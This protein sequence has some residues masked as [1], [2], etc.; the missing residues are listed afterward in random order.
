MAHRVRVAGLAIAAGIC[1][2]SV[3]ALNGHAQAPV[4]GPASASPTAVCV[5]CRGPDV[6]YRCEVKDSHRVERIRGSPRALEFVCITE[7]AKAG[8]HQSCRAGSN[9][10]GPCIG[11]PRLID[12]SKSG[13]AVVIG[14][15]PAGP[16]AAVGGVQAP[17]VATTSERTS[18]KPD[19]PPQTLEELARVTVSK[20]KKQIAEADEKMQEASGAVG[21]ALKKSWACLSSLFTDCK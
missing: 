16:P 13:D 7:L 6:T 17:D 3:L 11:E 15:N 20:S 18:V 14:S 9:F 19:G 4:D 2:S 12:L 10:S 21:K 8:K 5:Q 1:G